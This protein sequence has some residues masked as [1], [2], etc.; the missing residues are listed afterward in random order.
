MADAE[1]ARAKRRLQQKTSA[2]GTTRCSGREDSKELQL[3]VKI[4]M[5]SSKSGGCSE[6]GEQSRKE[7]SRRGKALTHR[8]GNQTTAHKPK[9]TTGTS[10][11]EGIFLQH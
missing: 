10:P 11:A 9:P 8:Q 4:P 1:D 7:Q 5:Q 6:G 3:T 2:A